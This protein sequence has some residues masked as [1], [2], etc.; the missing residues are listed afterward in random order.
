MKVSG[1]EGHLGNGKDKETMITIIH[2]D[3]G[4][5]I[6]SLIRIASVRGRQLS[7]KVA[8]SSKERENTNTIV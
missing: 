1:N 2:E 8:Q 4:R 3:T 6:S 5:G 7:K